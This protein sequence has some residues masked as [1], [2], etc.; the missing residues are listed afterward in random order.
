M[1]IGILLSI[2]LFFSS[3]D[4]LAEIPESFEYICQCVE[5][6]AGNQDELGRT[7]VADVIMNRAEQWD[8][9]FEEVINA[10]NAFSVVSN[11]SINE[12]EVKDSTREIVFNELK[13]RT[14]SEVLYFRT[15]KYHSFGTALFKH[16]AHYFSK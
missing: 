8:M 2:F 14:N 1:I 7:Y 16:G 5:A 11:G 9:T 13:E 15:G 10:K 3:P 12:V 4:L 6:E